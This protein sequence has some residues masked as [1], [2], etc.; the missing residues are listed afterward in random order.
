M[1]TI[2]L[3]GLEVSEDKAREM[4]KTI[5]EQL[6][7]PEF[8]KGQL[9]EGR[10]FDDDVWKIDT[11]VRYL[12]DTSLPYLCR[13]DP[14]KQCRP[15]QDPLI[16]QFRPHTPGDTMPCDGKQKVRV[17]YRCGDIDIDKAKEYDWNEAG[18]NTDIIGWLPIGDDNGKG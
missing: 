3:D 7:E 12:S 4:L 15:L 6:K 18:T 14:W 9:V 17:M 2:K 5:Q 11:F 13:N 10:D 16:I 1:K 8:Y